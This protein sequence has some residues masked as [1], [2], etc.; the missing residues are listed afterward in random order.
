MGTANDSLAGQA[1]EIVAYHQ[2]SRHFLCTNEKPKGK[3]FIL[4]SH[5]G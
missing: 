3:D 4:F 2:L 5:G 1:Q